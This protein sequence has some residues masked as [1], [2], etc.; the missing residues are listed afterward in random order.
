MAT[1]IIVKHKV[2]DYVTFKPGFDNLVRLFAKETGAKGH[3]VHHEVGDPNHVIITVLEVADETKARSLF[4]SDDFRA[5]MN[6]IGVC[7]SPEI[8]YHKSVESVRY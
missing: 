2:T 4:A 3:L 8:T 1:D 5:E 6:K 7:S